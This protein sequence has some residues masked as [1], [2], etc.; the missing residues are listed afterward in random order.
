MTSS[1]PIRLIIPP[2]KNRALH[3]THGVEVNCILLSDSSNID[4][5]MND[6]SQICKRSGTCCSN[7][8]ALNFTVRSA[9][10]EETRNAFLEAV[11]EIHLLKCTY[12]LSNKSQAAWN[13]VSPASKVTRRTVAFIMRVVPTF[14]IFVHS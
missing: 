5:W 6:F 12:T 1:Q 7:N 9:F 11:D 13:F 10:G 2:A 4:V 8:D 14:P 3:Y